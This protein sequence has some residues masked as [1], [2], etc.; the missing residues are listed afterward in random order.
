M[1]KNAKLSS[2]SRVYSGSYF[3]VYAISRR[4]AQRDRR[5]HVADHAVLRALSDFINN[6]LAI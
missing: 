3:D 1:I 4:V 5:S 6:P 2:V